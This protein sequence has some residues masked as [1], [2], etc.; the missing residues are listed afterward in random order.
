MRCKR[1]QVYPVAVHEDDIYHNRCKEE[2]NY[3]AV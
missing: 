2:D 1:I 3:I